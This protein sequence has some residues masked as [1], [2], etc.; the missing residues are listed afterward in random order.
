MAQFQVF[1]WHKIDAFFDAKIARK[2]ARIM[3]RHQPNG[4]RKLFCEVAQVR[5]G[6]SDGNQQS[7]GENKM[8]IFRH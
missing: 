8:A 3:P 7:F 2:H 1:A 4:L 6:A 5:V